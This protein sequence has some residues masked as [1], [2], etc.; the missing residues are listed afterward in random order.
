MLRIV[1]LI[2]ITIVKCWVFVCNS[3][4]LLCLKEHGFNFV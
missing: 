4:T 1:I 3:M 2:I